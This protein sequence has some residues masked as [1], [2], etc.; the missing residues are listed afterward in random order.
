[1]EANTDNIICGNGVCG[2]GI[3]GTSL[4]A[5]RWAGFLALANQQANGTPVGFLNPT[6]YSIG[7]GSSYGTDFHDITS[8]NNF[9]TAS[10]NL[11][12]AVTGYDLVTGWGSPN[13]QGLIDALTPASSAPYYALSASPTT[14]TIPATGGDGTSTIQLASGNGFTGTVTLSAVVVGPASGVTVSFNPTTVTGSGTS[15]MTISTTDSISGNLQ[16]VVSGTRAAFGSIEELETAIKLI[17]GPPR[18]V[19]IPDAGHSL[20]TKQNRMQL[21]RSIV[22][23]FGQMFLSRR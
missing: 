1:M 12:T 6:I 17:A 21:P 4:A 16:V 8:G 13:G 20:L 22:E 3:G 2:G 7:L 18:L 14:V 23:A 19:P 9:T 5:P 10:P 15:T 11:F